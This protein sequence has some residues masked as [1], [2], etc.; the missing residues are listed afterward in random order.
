MKPAESLFLPT[1]RWRLGF[2]CCALLMGAA[3]MD[4][5]PRQDAL[6]VNPFNMTQ[7][8]RLQAM[9]SIGDDAHTQRSWSYALLPGCVLQIDIDGELG[10]GPAS[11]VALLGSVIQ[12]ARDPTDNTFNVAV[13]GPGD[14]HSAAA[15]V[16]ESQD[17]GLAS[18]TQLL[19]RVLQRGCSDAAGKTGAT[20]AILPGQSPP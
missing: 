19:L 13:S 5:Y 4:G 18:Q 17:W 6:I 1:L 11:E 20:V 12:I 2:A 9:N 15:S 16:L 7:T 8:Q 10:P 3:C 14:S